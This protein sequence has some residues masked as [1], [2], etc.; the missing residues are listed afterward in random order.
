MYACRPR[1]QNRIF[2]PKSHKTGEL[3]PLILDAHGGGFTL[4]DAEFDDEFCS[5]FANKFNVV[6]VSIDYSTA[7]SSKF[8]GPTNDI[9]EIAQAVIEDGTLPIDKSRVVLN[10]FSAGGNLCLSAAQKPEL[11]NKIKGV[12]SWYPV[13]DFTLT[14]AEKQSSRTYRNAK[15][16]D[17]L[18]NWGPVWDWGY[19]SPGQDIRD[20]LLSVRFA[21]REYLPSWIY[22]I[23]AEY[24]MLANEARQTIFDIANLDKLEREDIERSFEKDTYKWTL[25]K[26][27]R[28]GFTHDLMDHRGPEAEAM[29]K[30]KTHEMV[31]EVGGWLFRGPFA[32]A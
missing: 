14:P 5:T 29:R 15:D 7:P 3:L 30:K 2:I 11:K 20:P 25:V 12:V 31:E 19:I 8:P 6:I 17:D 16:T 21:R 10:G 13:A 4:L 22:I 1:L 28:H 24:D 26:D 9:V 18:K 32:Q 27:V 23:G